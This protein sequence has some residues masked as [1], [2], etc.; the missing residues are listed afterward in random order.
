MEYQQGQSK[1]LAQT[2]NL[3]LRIKT[4]NALDT[5][6]AVSLCIKDHQKPDFGNE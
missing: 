4:V 6:G 1:Y 2:G 5:V 3:I